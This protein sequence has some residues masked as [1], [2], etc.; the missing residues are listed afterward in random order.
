TQQQLL[1]SK[2]TWSPGL[3]HAL[4]YEQPEDWVEFLGNAQVF[5]LWHRVRVGRELFRSCVAFL[6]QIGMDRLLVFVDQVEDFAN[7]VTPYYKLRRDFPRLAYLC[8]Q[9]E[10]VNNHVTFILTMHPRAARVLYRYWPDVAIGP[11]GIDEKAENT[12]CLGPM[13]KARFAEMVMTYLDSA[14]LKGPTNTLSPFTEAAID[15]VHKEEQGR[16][17]YCLQ[18]LHY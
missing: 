6:R 10:I 12:V 16:A 15:L 17:G 2:E 3:L 7:F 5:S 11:I 9:D 18:R 4:C 8:T 1:Q 13:N 14:R